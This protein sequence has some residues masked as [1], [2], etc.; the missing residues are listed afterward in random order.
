[1]KKGLIDK[2]LSS[3]REV[4]IKEISVDMMDEIKDIPQLIF[5]NGVQESIR[6]VNKA[7]TA[8]LRNGLAGGDFDNWKPNG[9]IAPD[10][11]LKQL[12][13]EE[14]TELVAIVQ[15]CQIVNPKKPSS[16]V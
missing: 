13:P 2:K 3:G 6:N 9:A 11:V 15:E 16:S 4:K 8:W 5:K 14:R 7:Q 1:M 12:T 10:H